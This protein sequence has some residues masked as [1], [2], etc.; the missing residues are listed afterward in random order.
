VKQ[1]KAHTVIIP[2][3]GILVLG[4]VFF[5]LVEGWNWLDSYFFTVI[6]ISTVGY[7]TLVPLT[8]LGKIGATVFIFVGLGVFVVAIQQF[9]QYHMQ[10][11]QEHT[12]WL[13]DRLGRQPTE[14]PAATRDMQPPA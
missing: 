13:V 9:A 12:E 7:G 14:D 8:A 2:L 4:T 10:K 1:F 11:R 3:V 6:T 5:H